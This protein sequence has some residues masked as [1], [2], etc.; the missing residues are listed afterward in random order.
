[1]TLEQSR[2]RN[3]EVLCLV[4]LVDL[5]CSVDVGS[6][7]WFSDLSTNMGHSMKLAGE[8]KSATS[9]ER[10]TLHAV[11]TS[12]SALRRRCGVEIYSGSRLVTALA[13]GL[14]SSERTVSPP[15]RKSAKNRIR[16]EELFHD[17]YEV[18]AGHSCQWHYVHATGASTFT[19]LAKG[20][21]SDVNYLYCGFVAP[22]EP[23]IGPYRPFTP[24]EMHIEQECEQILADDTPISMNDEINPSTPAANAAA[25]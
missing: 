20:F 11:I 14:C 12:L 18:A 21:G 19:G 7:E 17:L 4:T 5:R 2:F 24:H 25:A 6:G 13:P 8:S 15:K 10:L 3:S 16:N 22:W 9:F 1:M 23:A